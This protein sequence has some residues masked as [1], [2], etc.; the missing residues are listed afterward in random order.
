[1][2]LRAEAGGVAS[3]GFS[4]A[5]LGGAG[6]SPANGRITVPNASS[7]P[8]PG[9]QLGVPTAV[10]GWAELY[11][12]CSINSGSWTVTAPP[13][14]GSVSFATYLGGADACGN[15]IPYNELY[16]TWTDPNPKATTNSFS[17]TWQ[18]A[19]G[20]FIEPG[21]WTFGRASPDKQIGQCTCSCPCGGNPI[22]LSTG[23][24]TEAVTDYQTAGANRL[25]FARYYNFVPFGT[26]AALQPA[27]FA[28]TL[29]RN[30]RSNFD[31]YLREVRADGRLVAIV[32]ER[33]DGQLLS[34]APDGN[35]WVSD[36]DVDVKLTQSGSTFTLVDSDDTVE[37]YT[38]VSSVEDVPT[39]IRARDGYTQILQYNSG[40]RLVS[41]ADSY[42]R[43]LSFTY[44]K[45]LL[46]TVATPDG[47][48]LTYGYDSQ[49]RLASVAYST[50]PQTSQTY[51]YEDSAFPT[52]LTGIVDEDGNL[53]ASWTYDS[54][55]RVTSSQHAGGADL[56]TVA[57][58]DTDGSRTVTNALG[59]QT[60][61]S[62]A[63]LQGVPKVIEMDR[64]ASTTTAAAT[65]TTAYDANGY[66][67]RLTDW[68]GKLTTYVNDARGLPTRITEAVGTPQQRKT[69]IAWLTNFH[70]PSDIDAPEL[71]TKFVYNVSG[72][73]LTRTAIDTTRTSVPYSTR[74]TSRTWTYTWSNFLLASVKAPRTDIAEL[75]RFG[76]DSSGALVAI[77]N[78]LSQTT[79]ITRNSPGGLPETIVDPNDVTTKLTYDARQR[80]LT[81]TIEAS[82]GLTT[83]FA[84][85]PAGNLTG[86]TLPD[87]S[88]LAYTYDAA[89]RLVAIADLLGNHVDYT[90][91]PLGDRT[92]TDLS[93][94]STV[95]LQH[96]AVFDALGRLIKDIGGVGQTTSYA[97]DADGN[98]TKTTDPLERVTT[99]V[100]DALDRLERVT[101]PA[102]GVT[103]TAYD[104]QNHPVTVTDPNGNSTDYA[105][106]GFGD[107]IE[108]DSPDSG[109]AVS[110]YDADGNL[111]QRIDA[112]GNVTKN[113]YDALDRPISTDYPGATAENVAYTYDQA[114]GDFGIGRLTTVADAVGTAKYV[115]DQRGNLLRET[116]A[117]AAAVA[118]TGYRY[119]RADR[120]AAVTYPSGWTASYTRDAMGRITAIAAG[121]PSG[122]PLPV[123][124]AIA[125]LPFGP[126]DAL[127]YGN[128]IAETRAFDLDYR[129]TG[130]AAVD[131]ANV[132]NLTYGYDAADNVLS[133]ADA[134]TP[135]SSQNFAYDR[136]NRL[137]RAAGGYG[138]LTYAYDPVGNRLSQA[139]TAGGTTTRQNYLYL[140]HS[141]RLSEIS[142]AGSAIR[143]FAYGPTGNIERDQRSNETLG[144]V[145][146]QANRLANVT[147]ATAKI[148]QYTYDAFGRRLVKTLPGNPGSPQLYLY[149][150]VGHLLEES[151][152]A[153]GTARNRLDYIYLEDRPVA[154]L[155][156]GTGGLFFLHGDRLNSP[157]LAT[158]PQQGVDWKG[159]Y[160]PFG[161]IRLLVDAVSQNL[162]FPGQYA[163]AETGYY[164]NGFRDYDPTLGRYVESDPI[165]LAG[166]LN[167]YAYAMNNPL[168]FIDPVG[169]CPTYKWKDGTVRS[170]PEP[171]GTGAQP[172]PPDPTPPPKAP[173]DNPVSSFFKSLFN[174]AFGSLNK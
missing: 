39:S 110:H 98:P 83:T 131:T 90:L 35:A 32:A 7:G 5:F 76:Y 157:Q 29:G 114:S 65:E 50:N 129:E 111:V 43:K 168:K 42:G 155:V 132:Q 6:V 71:T 27:V 2:A 80:L 75:T 121:R 46:A 102:R 96:S 99:R 170:Y 152:L 167:T 149:D 63:T 130:L 103:A 18:S 40:H 20:R 150:Q 123:V 48:V 4:A 13:S 166:G 141:N 116:R 69:T 31:R 45:G 30:W 159:A 143:R 94:G 119:D 85:D 52:A 128:G 101:D 22:V 9:V 15:P 11:N 24:K 148:A 47:L 77:T 139:Q 125:Y 147:K 56:T 112:A 38:P 134:V 163:D 36:S 87:G 171:A 122:T 49:G 51:Q 154:M 72:D 59:Q 54:L 79:R 173:N 33:N 160:Q 17:A 133:I 140:P 161:Q 68:N 58:D 172:H 113:A 142:E 120:I 81:R 107:V 104:P 34:F 60:V 41:V 174:G 165:G 146:N 91:D 151:S 124:S 70:L 106:D 127:S 64:L 169:D 61:Y 84:Y 21:T 23:G 26:G 158:G 93:A 1:M 118:Q 28:A 25:G 126:V 108:T 44:Q 145:Y 164:H 156:A 37:T 97:Y 136:L 62:F 19:D 117:H 88:A 73:L 137:T 3:G 55:G 162:R 53:F 16:Y 105:Y 78:A 95:A 92:A 138:R 135:G 14:H 115:Y 67:A 8:A 57:Y 100:F 153:A 74:G 89:H 109:I 86:V 66:P 10:I 82:G 144:L 12:G